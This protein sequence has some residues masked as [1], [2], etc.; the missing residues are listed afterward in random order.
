ML[1]VDKIKL[2]SNQRVSSGQNAMLSV[3]LPRVRPVAI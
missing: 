3:V 1:Q 2:H